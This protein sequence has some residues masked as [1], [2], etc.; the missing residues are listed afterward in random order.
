V[1]LAL[2]RKDGLEK[3]KE[4]C[5]HT[6]SKTL[7]EDCGIARNTFLCN[8]RIVVVSSKSKLKSKLMPSQVQALEEQV[9]A[10]RTIGD[11][12]RREVR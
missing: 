10:E 8:T 6:F 12:V 4:E 2:P 1:A 11:E 7:K 5:I 3:S 9:L